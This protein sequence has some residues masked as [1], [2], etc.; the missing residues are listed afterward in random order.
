MQIQ[1]LAKWKHQGVD[2]GKDDVKTFDDVTGEYF[3]KAGVG[4]D[5]T[6]STPTATPNPNET[7]TLDVQA[8]NQNEVIANG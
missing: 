7:I 2:Y 5:L 6:G 1:F 4:K 3:C 8:S